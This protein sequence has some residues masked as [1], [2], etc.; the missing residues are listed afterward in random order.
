MI[1]NPDERKKYI[2]IRLMEYREGILVFSCRKRVISLK[3]G[4]MISY[5]L[6][7]SNSLA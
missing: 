6:I 2:I 5:N 7:V 1:V 3:I 4:K